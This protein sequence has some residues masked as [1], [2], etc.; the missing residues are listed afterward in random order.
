MRLDLKVDFSFAVAALPVSARDR[1][2]LSSGSS[3]C[4]SPGTRGWFESHSSVAGTDRDVTF[5]KFD[6]DLR[7]CKDSGVEGLPLERMDRSS[8]SKDGIDSADVD[9]V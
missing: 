8:A 4:G 2:S 1:F 3:S 5:F 7:L 9:R 6:I